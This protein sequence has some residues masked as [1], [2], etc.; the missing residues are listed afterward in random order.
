MTLTDQ[1][2][3]STPLHAFVGAGDLVVERIRHSAAT[4]DEAQAS[5]Q[6]AAQARV[7]ALISELRELPEQLR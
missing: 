7:D 1:L 5:A 2:K 4:I 3:K 6:A